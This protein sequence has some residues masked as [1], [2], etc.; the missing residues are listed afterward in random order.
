M[1][2]NRI[3]EIGTRTMACGSWS[4]MAKLVIQFQLVLNYCV[5]YTY[6]HLKSSKSTCDYMCSNCFR[7][8]LPG[9]FPTISTSGKRRQSSTISQVYW[10]L[11]ELCLRSWM[12]VNPSEAPRINETTKLWGVV[13]KVVWQVAGCVD[14]FQV[15]R[16]LPFVLANK[17]KKLP[18]ECRC[19]FYPSTGLLVG[20]I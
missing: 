15:D 19:P 16:S 2:E 4:I 20:A 18:P 14:N 11:S 6:M 8:P 7:L 9:N 17:T 5:S 1:I 3:R 10:R 12:S 13:G